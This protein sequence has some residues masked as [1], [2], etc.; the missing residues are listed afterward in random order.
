M[1]GSVALIDLGT[2]AGQGLRLI[3]Q[4]Y[5]RHPRSSIITVA[6]AAL[7][8]LEWPAR[9]FGVAAFL[10]E[11]VSHHDLGRICASYLDRPNV[12]AHS[13]VNSATFH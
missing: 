5:T 8:D 7:A 4:I 12:D 6:P 10:V 13:V 11:S 3:T 1:P 2:G 9:E